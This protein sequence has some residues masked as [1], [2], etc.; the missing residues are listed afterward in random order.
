MPIGNVLLSLRHSSRR[1]NE[2]V[3][4]RTM[5]AQPDSHAKKPKNSDSFSV[6]ANSCRVEGDC[7]GE[8]ARYVS[9]R[10]LVNWRLRWSIALDQWWWSVKSERA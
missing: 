6:T 5:S 2:E 8:P 7:S 10:V 3:D 1:V 9:Y 4:K